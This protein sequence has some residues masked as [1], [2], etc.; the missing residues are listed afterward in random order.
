MDTPGLGKVVMPILRYIWRLIW[1]K[2][3]KDDWWV[4]YRI[5]LKSDK[6]HRMRMKVLTRDKFRCQQCD[7]GATQ[8]HHLTYE[9]VGN[10]RMED[11]MSLCKDCHKE[12]HGK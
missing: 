2:P 5:Y 11:L 4:W 6:W 9:R 1:G 12:I 7:R 3:K 10:E 8:V